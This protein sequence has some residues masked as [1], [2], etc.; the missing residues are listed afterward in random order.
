MQLRL[1]S[2]GSEGARGA[3]LRQPN[4]KVNGYKNNGRLARLY[5]RQ[6]RAQQLLELRAERT[7]M[8][9]LILLEHRPGR[10]AKERARLWLRIDP[11]ARG[12][13][14]YEGMRE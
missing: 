2:Y 13:V 9:Q 3:S 10:C 8:Q 5:I 14:L 12:H 1:R 4:P 7:D 6:I 11:A